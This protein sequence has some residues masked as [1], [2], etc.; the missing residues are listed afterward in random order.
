M[1]FK[2]LLR[3]SLAVVLTAGQIATLQP[4][5]I[6]A[7][8]TAAPLETAANPETEATTEDTDAAL[9]ADADLSTEETLQE[10]Q[11]LEKPR[12]AA[13]T[14]IAVNPD[15][16]DIIS[17]ED[18]AYITGADTQEDTDAL[19]ALDSVSLE[20]S[21]LDEEDWE[22]A[23][24]D[25]LPEEYESFS[26]REEAVTYITNQM[27]QRAAD[28]NVSLPADELGITYDQ[29]KNS[30]EAVGTA[31]NNLIAAAYCEPDVLEEK[32]SLST[33]A[34]DYLRANYYGHKST[35]Y[36]MSANAGDKVYLFYDA[37]YTSTKEQEDAVDEKVTEIIDE[38]D[39]DSKA[40]T[41][42][43]IKDIHDYI[44]NKVSYKED[45]AQL[46]TNE[47]L[48]YHS[49]Y[50]ALVGGKSVCQG[51]ASAFLRL[52]REEGIP[53]RYITGMGYGY[54]GNGEGHGWNIVKL[55]NCWYNVDT[56]WDDGGAVRYDYFL[57]S[58][59]D[60]TTLATE[61]HVRD[62]EYSTESFNASYPMA[63]KSYDPQTDEEY[64][65]LTFIGDG[66]TELS[67]NSY[68]SDSNQ[69]VHFDAKIVDGI[70]REAT[71]STNYAVKDE[72]FK[73]EAT[74]A[75]ELDCAKVL[76]YTG[77]DKSSSLA[78]LIDE[79]TQKEY[80]EVT[81]S[82]N[83][84]I[85][86]TAI[87]EGEASYSYPADTRYEMSVKA[88]NFSKFGISDKSSSALE[89]ITT[90][91]VTEAPADS[92][93]NISGTVTYMYADD[94]YLSYRYKDVSD[95]AF[96]KLT[97]VAAV[98]Y[99][100]D[101]ENKTKE[102]ILYP[103][104]ETDDRGV[105]DGYKIG[106]IYFEGDT[107]IKQLK[108]ADTAITDPKNVRLKSLDF[109]ETKIAD[110]LKSFALADI[111]K[112]QNQTGSTINTLKLAG[113]WKLSFSASTAQ[114]SASPRIVSAEYAAANPD[115]VA[116]EDVIVSVTSLTP[117]V[118]SV[119]S[120]D[121]EVNSIA[122][123]ANK[124]GTATIT[125]KAYFKRDEAVKDEA[126]K[127]LTTIKTINVF[128]PTA[129]LISINGQYIVTFD[130]TT[131]YSGWAKLS[132]KKVV[133]ASKGQK[134]SLYFLSTGDYVDTDNLTATEG[135][136]GRLAAAD[137]AGAIDLNDTEAFTASSSGVLAKDCSVWI[138]NT[139]L[140]SFD[141]DGKC[142]RFPWQRLKAIRILDGD[143][144][145]IE[146]NALTIPKGES[147]KIRIEYIPESD[148]ISSGNI[149]DTTVID[150]ASSDSEMVK[151]ENVVYTKSRDAS[152]NNI[153][154]CTAEI[155][156]ADYKEDGIITITAEAGDADNKYKAYYE[157]KEDEASLKNYL[158]GTL[159]ITTLKARGWH[160]LDGKAYYY[161]NDGNP[162][163]GW[164]EFS[165]GVK[166]Y[167]Y[168]NED[169]TEGRA[170][171]GAAVGE[172]ATGIVQLAR[173][174]SVESDDYA[175]YKFGL[176][177][178]LISE[179]IRDGWYTAD[180]GS[181]Y[182]YDKSSEILKSGVYTIE[183]KKYLFAA[184]G[185]LLINGVYKVNEKI[186]YVNKNG[187]L[188]T[189]WQNAVITDDIDTTFA[190]AGK[191]KK[192]YFD[193]DTGEILTGFVTISGKTYYLCETAMGTSYKGGVTKGYIELTSETA[194]KSPAGKYYLDNSGVVK[195]G[196]I[197]FKAD[198][199]NNTWHYFA[200]ANGKELEFTETPA[201]DG[202]SYYRSIAEGGITKNYYFPNNGTPY[203]YTTNAKGKIVKSNLYYEDES[204]SHYYINSNGTL[205]KGWLRFKADGI[206]NTWHYFDLE[207]G[208][209]IECQDS[210]IFTAQD[211]KSKWRRITEGGE[212][213]YFY[214]PSD[215]SLAK[216]FKNLKGLYNDNDGVT[217]KYYFDASYGNLKMGDFAVGNA[218]YH[219]DETTGAVL[220]NGW[221][222]YY[223]DGAA[224]GEAPIK[225]CYYN[226]SGKRVSGWNNLAPRA[227][228]LKGSRRYYFDN[229]GCLVTG[230]TSIGGKNYLL[231]DAENYGA[232]LPEG[233]THTRGEL[234]KSYYGATDGK[235]ITQE[236][237]TAMY[238]T[239]SSGILMTGWQRFK[240]D[241]TAYSWHLFDHNSA[242]ELISGN[243]NI[244]ITK[245][246][247]AGKM[248]DGWVSADIADYNVTNKYYFKNNRFLTGWQTIK[249][250]EG[251]K[252][253][254][255]FDKTT[256]ILKSGRITDGRTVYYLS[257]SGEQTG[258]GLVRING[259]YM[260][261][262]KNGA[263]RKGWFTA[264]GNKYY[265]DSTTGYLYTGFHKI[266]GK[267]YYF[268]EVSAA[269]GIMQ[270][271]FFRIY[272]N[273]QNYYDAEGSNLYYADAKGIVKT[274]GWLAIAVN[275]KSSKSAKIYYYLN[276]AIT[277][278]SADGNAVSGEVVTGE[279]LIYD[280]GSV[281]KY[282][283]DAGQDIS[284]KYSFD[285]T[286]GAQM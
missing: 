281:E 76:V 283:G 9:K 259:G 243:G 263:A 121:A 179:V 54:Q 204:G 41:Y 238:Y 4:E 155:I 8:E 10:A 62:S 205:T 249:D 145:E 37:A 15:Y 164:Q 66:L 182:Y 101:G 133:K 116:D 202:K 139:T 109:D 177:G 231:C 191:K 117:S 277:G 95:T 16:A 102:I 29:V 219:A 264:D 82:A 232:G 45:I 199:K 201:E 35:I 100:E 272:N 61:D 188:L 186:Y 158:K 58:N 20:G 226:A 167:F 256:G 233:Y 258:A 49:T 71:A 240:A 3:K 83:M 19:E 229:N 267:L 235:G 53:T 25:G 134:G 28:V 200:L 22:E 246:E 126:G 165:D 135:Y 154:V 7:E 152:G 51:Y 56:T 65:K 129:E 112:G 253:K 195:T 224:G 241:G 106:E 157:T 80:Y 118:L 215:S 176:D 181:K 114:S 150:F 44:V 221:K 124:T 26:T 18:I 144:N 220:T 171:I 40:T 1:N 143:G 178:K 131:R 149:T 276:P 120:S 192:F 185:R 194:S 111:P 257:D 266:S 103:A 105:A 227:G 163:T 278:V 269:A 72:A 172:M 203:I 262:D 270:T 104:D 212:S 6:M 27:V 137:S 142:T 39:P 284:K 242:Q 2:R 78:P 168:T 32:D 207:D 180:D 57:K 89:G 84:T 214:F 148:G 79:T 33:H 174:A 122:I 113:E 166:Y 75:P 17:E 94:A 274:S 161:D 85:H 21:E 175:Y 31:M 140:Y 169:I 132:G 138:D 87:P 273:G 275:P 48:V 5:Y 252:H 159:S 115:D 67:N 282:T 91:T 81:P 251:V 136:P 218:Y 230:I 24:Q 211:G 210:D 38:L 125:A 146:D 280:D 108:K 110:S 151:V 197:R 12:I 30:D 153:L 130:G 127:S 55:G 208:A 14:T 36:Y 198:G 187:I 217:R 213:K 286:T 107:L 50:S 42:E 183:G 96:I 260:Y 59:A 222:D 99:T 285:T 160:T 90:W 60:F 93:G 74:L 73:F 68:C 119:I 69:Y 47:S 97:P 255:Y 190:T 34:G 279:V 88:E 234:L 13:F 46:D 248:A 261:L 245:Q 268:S 162:L 271:G 86:V 206:N 244:T 247:T 193:P 64:V 173:Y 189:G 63:E 43:R 52:C 147:Q 184:D 141:A 170:P 254:Y 77:N 209:E 216:G 265:A 239:N 23:L 250:E 92:D 228:G 123:Q 196:W 237:D 225:T 236:A 223:A 128:C 70:T 11:D 156:A 98:S